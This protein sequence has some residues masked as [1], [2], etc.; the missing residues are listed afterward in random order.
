ML[1][2][3]RTTMT[4]LREPDD[5][6]EE[7]AVQ[8]RFDDSAPIVFTRRQSFAAI[9]PRS[10]R[11]KIEQ[12]K[13][14]KLFLNTGENDENDAGASN[15]RRSSNRRKFGTK[16][17]KTPL[18][19]QQRRLVKR[20]TIGAPST[21]SQMFASLASTPVEERDA[22]CG[23]KSWN[24]IRDGT[25]TLKKQ[26][27][28]P[29]TPVSSRR[30]ASSRQSSLSRRGSSSFIVD[31][32]KRKVIDANAA[33]SAANTPNYSTDGST[34]TDLER[35]TLVSVK[36]ML[37]LRYHGAVIPQEHPLFSIERIDPACWD[38]AINELNKVSVETSSESN[39]QLAEKAVVFQNCLRCISVRCTELHE[40]AAGADMLLPALIFVLMNSAVDDIVGLYQS[41]HKVRPNVV[42]RHYNEKCLE[43]TLVRVRSWICYRPFPSNNTCVSNNEIC[44]RFGFVLLALPRQK[45]NSRCSNKCGIK[46]PK[47][48]RMR[49]KKMLILTSNLTISKMECWFSVTTRVCDK[50]NRVLLPMFAAMISCNGYW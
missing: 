13:K 21:H 7:P 2:H 15:R 12:V 39:E 40:G 50:E 30:A 26:H 25:V 17:K 9:P 48:E 27:S 14:P 43:A 23:E 31:V 29:P 44:H 34:F 47:K 19:R 18:Y 16:K 38:T 1:P 8:R 5:M 11:P 10:N 22:R 41:L 3:R 45:W 46:L 49:K 42:A 32:A 35:R 33:T 24:S 4:F 20:N 28:K 37:Q 36:K 6:G